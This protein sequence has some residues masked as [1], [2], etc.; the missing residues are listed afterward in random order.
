[1]EEIEESKSV[2]VESF[3]DSPYIRVL[4]FMLEGQ[5]FD[6]SMTEVARGAHVGWSVFTKIWASLLEKKAII[7]TREIG[8]AKLFKLN[9]ENPVVKKLIQLDWELTKLAADQTLQKEVVNQF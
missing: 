8:D 7:Q 5:M 6:Y 4:D 1:M 9:K 2:F 3:G